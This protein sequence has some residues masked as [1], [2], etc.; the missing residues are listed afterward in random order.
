LKYLTVSAKPVWL[1]QRFAGC[2]CIVATTALPVAAQQTNMNTTKPLS[3][4]TISRE[5]R[6]WTRWWW[7]GSAVDEAEITRH[8][9]L[10]REAGIGGVE[11]SPLYGVQGEEKQ[12]IP[13]L[14]PRWMDMLGHTC[15]KPNGWTWAL[16]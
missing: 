14:S 1:L 10:F 9:Q 3:W 2:A 4:P 16:I 11:I 8:L 6:P 5:A 13:F 7:M 12:N 15:V